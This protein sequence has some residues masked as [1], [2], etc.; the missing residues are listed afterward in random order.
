MGKFDGVLL[1][2]DFDNTIVHTS[3]LYRSAELR[4][5]PVPPANLERLHYFMEQGGRFCVATGRAWQ[6]M[7][8]FI[9]LVPTNGACGVANGAGII[10]IPTEQFL[11]ARFLPEDVLLRVKEV[12]EQFPDLTCEF[13]RSDHHAD[14][15]NPIPFTDEH[16]RGS[17]YTYQVISRPEETR[18]PLLKV[19]FEG[20]PS[21]LE[22]IAVYI[23]S[24]PWF[25]GYELMFS[26]DQLLELTVQGANK[27]VM[28]A[29][30]AKLYGI[31]PAHVYCAGDQEN[32][33]PMLRFAREG[34]APANAI[35]AV[36]AAGVTPVCHCAQGALAEIIDILDQRY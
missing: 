19:L 13:F 2:S 6:I 14:A 36:L 20:D 33:L 26:G 15:I 16:A 1:V 28:A 22:Q 27:G 34:F 30:L 21:L 12:R 35:P 3:A 25:A 9:H 5:P 29:E 24:Q 7:R 10:D 32:D 11:Y 31:D 17:H 4:M 18:L 8:P 23:R